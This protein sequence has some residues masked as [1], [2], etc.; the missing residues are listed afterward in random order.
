MLCNS[1]KA[2]HRALALAVLALGERRGG[3][4]GNGV[5]GGE[6]SVRLW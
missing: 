4:A 3:S 5:E 2:L 6:T 1:L